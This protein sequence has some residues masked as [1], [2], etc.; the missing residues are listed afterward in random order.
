MFNCLQVN[1]LFAKASQ[2]IS[3]YEKFVKELL[4]NKRKPQSNKVV[5]LSKERI[6]IIE[7]KLP[8]K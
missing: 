8:Q 4:N 5:D 2:K 7:R 3:R 1:I 6:V